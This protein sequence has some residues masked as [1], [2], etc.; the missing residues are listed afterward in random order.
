MFLLIF[1]LIGYI[2]NVIIDDDLYYMFIDDI[3]QFV[4]VNIRF[5]KSVQ[6]GGGGDKRSLKVYV[7]K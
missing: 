6:G 5:L 7:I 3:Q 4:W 2:K 1:L